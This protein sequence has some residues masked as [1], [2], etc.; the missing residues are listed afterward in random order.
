MQK[1]LFIILLLS[2]TTAFAQK[3][4]KLIIQPNK[5]LTLEQAI[6]HAIN[7]SPALNIERMKLDE[8]YIQITEKRLEQIPNIFLSSDLRSN[9]IIPATPVPANVFNTTAQEGEITYLKFN[10]KWNSSAGI[11][12]SYDI[13]NPESINSIAEQQHQ[14]KIQEYN[15]QISEDELRE[16]VA[17]A[18]AESVIAEEQK[19][20]LESDTTYYAGLL[21]NAEQLYI[22]EKISLSD[23]NDANRAYNESIVNYL[24]AQKI[25]YDRK[26]ELLY[27][28]GIDIT[29]ENIESLTLHEDITALL[30][31]MEQKTNNPYIASDTEELRQQE[32]VELANLR[33]KTASLKYAPTISLQGYYGTNFYNNELSLFNNKFWRG[34][35]YIG[36]SVRVPI[37]QS[38]STSKEVSRLRLNHLIES[39]SLRDIRNRQEKKRLN[40]LSLLHVRKENYRL[41]RENWE[42]SKQNSAAIQLQFEK[43][44]IKQIDLLNEKLKIQ[45]SRHK[46]LQSVYELFNALIMLNN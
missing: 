1:I 15:T 19:Q 22:K 24:D 29:I 3:S 7:H 38:F 32:L 18:Y 40:E 42:M 5:I 44:H 6:N 35:S 28:I 17:L 8:A 30:D 31:H 37:S 21:S 36:L 46:Y 9:L 25:T 10:T 13:F 27:L 33:V 23:K 45:Q 39:E 41:S 43:G 14:L 2:S 34:N 12:L 16:S 20:M 4:E 26:A 11:N